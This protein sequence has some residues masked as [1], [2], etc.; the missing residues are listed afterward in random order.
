M[1][2]NPSLVTTAFGNPQG[3]ERTEEANKLRSEEI[4]HAIK[5]ML[6]MDN[7]GFVPELTVWATNPW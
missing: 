7:R 3:I 6:E 2:I 1:E 4:A 5:S